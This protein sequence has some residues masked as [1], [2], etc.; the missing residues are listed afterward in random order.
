MGAT[1]QALDAPNLATYI[2]PGKV[3]QVAAAVRSLGAET[4]IF[5]DELSPAQLRNLEK[6]LSGGQ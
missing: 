6:A 5:D 1:H 4:V 2:G 3:A